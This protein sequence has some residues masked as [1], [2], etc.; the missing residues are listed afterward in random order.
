MTIVV[1]LRAF[2]SGKTRLAANLSVDERRRI[3]EACARSVLGSAGAAGSDRVVVCED[4]D[5]EQWALTIGARVVRVAVR[6]LNESLA[7][8]ELSRHCAGDTVVI[9]HGDLPLAER[10]IEDLTDVVTVTDEVVVVTDRHEDGTN[11]LVLPRR[12][13]ADWRFGYGPGSKERHLAEA[14]R[15]GLRARTVT[16]PRLSVDLDTADDLALPEVA[17]FV[18]AAIGR[19]GGI[20][21]PA[22]EIR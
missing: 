5:T 22:R 21:E 2:A 12:S 13:V 7:A 10:L 6:G 17:S 3:A 16:H 14:S 20:D 1:P 4:D 11:V 15:L 19:H 8:A 18:K 9:A